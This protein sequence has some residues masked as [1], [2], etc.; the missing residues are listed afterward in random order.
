VRATKLVIQLYV[1]GRP[2]ECACSARNN[3]VKLHTLLPVDSKS[4]FEQRKVL[5]CKKS[6]RSEELRSAMNIQFLHPGCSTFKAVPSGRGGKRVELSS[7]NQSAAENSR[8]N[9]SEKA[10]E[11]PRRV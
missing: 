8:K 9:K 10:A 11:S 5:L 2:L 4:Q 1:N 6:A 7:I 3:A